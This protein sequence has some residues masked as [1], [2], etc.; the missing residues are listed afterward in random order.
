MNEF[1]INPDYIHEI[2]KSY[3]NHLF[4]DEPI[5]GSE[6]RLIANIDKWRIVPIAQ[7][8]GAVTFRIE[9]ISCDNCPDIPNG[10]LIDTG[11]I[12]MGEI[13]DNGWVMGVDG[14]LYHLYD[15]GSK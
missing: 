4:K 6:Q 1:Y 15:A 12:K 5:P 9:G 13:S 7:Y 2:I 3:D 14:R 11:E 8:V 10:T